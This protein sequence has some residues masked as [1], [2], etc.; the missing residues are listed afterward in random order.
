MTAHTQRSYPWRAALPDE[1]ELT[2]R[3]IVPPMYAHL[4][5]KDLPF[6]PAASRAAHHGTAETSRAEEA[7]A[8]RRDDANGQHERDGILARTWPRVAA[9]RAGAK[10]RSVPEG[11]AGANL[12]LSLIHI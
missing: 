5:L 9:V 6:I 4:H 12:F 10:A 3:P 1:P 11:D 2:P 7:D 8:G